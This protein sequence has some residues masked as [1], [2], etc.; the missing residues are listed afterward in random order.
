MWGDPLHPDRDPPTPPSGMEHYDSLNNIEIID[1]ISINHINDK[2]LAGSVIDK[3]KQIE[4]IDE[5][6]MALDETK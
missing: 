5:K 1:N 3:N 4:K 2:K 6:N